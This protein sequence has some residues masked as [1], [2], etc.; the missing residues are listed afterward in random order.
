[1]TREKNHF[2]FLVGG[3]GNRLV[4]PSNTLRVGLTGP[5]GRG[6]KS[7][8]MKMEVMAPK[9]LPFMPRFGWHSAEGAQE[10]ERWGIEVMEKPHQCCMGHAAGGRFRCGLSVCWPLLALL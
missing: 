9:T 4:C 7:P 5:G 2:S 8:F 10:R 6:Q 1:M 3:K